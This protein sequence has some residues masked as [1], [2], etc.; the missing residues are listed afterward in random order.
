MAIPDSQSLL[1]PLLKL[2]SDGR[3]HAHRESIEAMAVEFKLT[4]EEKKEML[5]S[6]NMA[7]F[8]QRVS[9]AKHRLK[10]AG[11]LENP[12][13]GI[14]KITERGLKELK[15][16]PSEINVKYLKELPE[17]QQR[18]E[19]PEGESDTEISDNPPEELMGEAYKRIR[20]ELADEILV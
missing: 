8:D 12:R 7:L 5:P 1:L 3:E 4:E 16:N 6:G 19:A 10:K 11:L 17:Y 14:H 13:K 15:K 20:S 18:R 9:W 2:H